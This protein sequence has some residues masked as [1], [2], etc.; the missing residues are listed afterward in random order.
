MYKNDGWGVAVLHIEN[1]S[2]FGQSEIEGS[3]DA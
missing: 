2:Y 3:A 1:K